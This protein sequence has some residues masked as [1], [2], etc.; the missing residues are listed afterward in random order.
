MIAW[1]GAPGVILYRVENQS[2]DPQ[3]APVSIPVSTLHRINSFIERVKK[4]KDINVDDAV[5]TFLQE[6]PDIAI[7]LRGTF[8]VA[9]V[10]V[11]VATIIEDI[12]TA[13]AGI[14]DDGP[15]FYVAYRLVA[16]ALK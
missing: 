5:R 4:I 12:V 8:I 2:P 10:A 9:G 6:N 3:P 16:I 15:T 13:G 14:A 7:F 11:A 1:Q